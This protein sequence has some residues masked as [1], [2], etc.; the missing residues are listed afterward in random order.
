MPVNDRVY[1]MSELLLIVLGISIDVILVI[2][3]HLLS[4]EYTCYCHDIVYNW[5]RFIIF[6]VK[7]ITEKY[8]SEKGVP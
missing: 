2:Y 5:Y 7:P 8:Q 4:T 3:M 6:D 1:L